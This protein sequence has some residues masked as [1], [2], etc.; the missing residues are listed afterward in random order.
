[1]LQAHSVWHFVG[2][3]RPVPKREMKDS[4][5]IKLG[6]QGFIKYWKDTAD[7]DMSGQYMESIAPTI[8]YWENVLAAMDRPILPTPSE[9]RDPFWPATRFSIAPTLHVDNVHLLEENVTDY[10]YVGPASSRPVESFRPGA[11]IRVGH[12]VLLRPSEDCPNPVWMGRVISEPNLAHL[13]PHPR[14]I[15]IVYY[16][17]LLG[18]RN[19]KTLDER[20]EEWDT[21]K[22]FRWTRLKDY[23]PAHQSLDCVV[24]SWARQR[25]A[26]DDNVL[27]P[28]RQILFAKDNL[29]RCVRGEKMTD[30]DTFEDGVPAEDFCD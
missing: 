20:Y 7:Q 12:Y 8:A 2:C 3:P 1:M 11:H 26:S 10:A 9:L 4:V 6:V 25:N 28:A 23:P 21:A 18:Q 24:A 15:E 14:S 13:G 19:K 29:D 5:N 22:A 17:P 16:V 27:I 30:G